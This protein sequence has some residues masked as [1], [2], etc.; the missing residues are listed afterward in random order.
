MITPASAGLSSSQDPASCGGWHALHADAL[1]AQQAEPCACLQEEYALFTKAAQLWL[2][3]STLV[4]AAAELGRTS[5]AR[6]G[7]YMAISQALVDAGAQYTLPPYERMK[8]SLMHAQP[9]YGEGQAF[10]PTFMTKSALKL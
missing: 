6:H 7:L 1:R 5:R 2:T 3:T 9:P 8:D 4:F 10:M